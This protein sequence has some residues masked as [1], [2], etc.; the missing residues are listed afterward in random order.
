MLKHAEAE[1][2]CEALYSN[3]QN[4]IKNY[5]QHEELSLKLLKS[6][7]RTTSC[8]IYEKKW[9]EVVTFLDETL[10][11]SAVSGT[12]RIPNDEA[13]E[14]IL[15]IMMNLVKYSQRKPN[16][17]QLCFNFT[18]KVSG[19][20]T[21]KILKQC[22]DILCKMFTMC[23]K[24]KISAE[25]IKSLYSTHYQKVESKSILEEKTA[26]FLGKLL[27]NNIQL[28]EA[29]PDFFYSYHRLAIG[30]FN[31]FKY[32]KNKEGVVSCCNDIKRHSTNNMN[33]TVMSLAAKTAKAGNHNENFGK[34][35]LY[36]ATY[37]A[38]LVEDLKCQSKQKEMISTYERLY[39]VIYEV[40]VL[41]GSAN[42]NLSHL[43]QCADV[44]LKL[45]DKLPEE[46]I[47]TSIEPDRLVQ[48]IY[49]NPIT[50]EDAEICANGVALLLLKRKEL[51]S[52]LDSSRDQKKNLMKM[53]FELRQCIKLLEYDSATEYLR[54]KH[55]S[56]T[57]TNL[58]T[59]TLIEM[60]AV[61]R[62]EPE[63]STK[64]N[65]DLFPKL[66]NL[67]KCPLTLAQACQSIS[68]E[69]IKKIPI[70]LFK[71]VNK[72]LEF[73]EN[74]QFNLEVS[75]SLALNNYWIF[76]VTAETVQTDMKDKSVGNLNLKEE[77]EILKRLNES[78]R[79]FTEVV[80]HISKHKKDVEK[81]MS[82]QRL[83]GII[84][85]MAIQ[86]Y[87]RGIK[88]KDLEAFTLLWHI[89]LIDGQQL[90]P[91]LNVATFFL[92]HVELLTDSS[93]NYIKMSK[94]IKPLTI[95][96]IVA[97]SNALVDERYMMNFEEQLAT[98]QYS[99]WSYLLSL[100]VYYLQQGRH[101]DGQKRWNQFKTT[102]KSPKT[103]DKF[104]HRQIIEAKMYFCLVEINMKC[105]QRTAVNFLSQGVSILVRAKKVSRDF[106]F[107]YY[108]IYNHISMKV[109]NYSLNRLVD[110]THY[111]SLLASMI[112]SSTKRGHCVK[113]I[114]LLSLS[115]MRNLSMEKIENAKVRLNHLRMI[116]YLMSNISSQAQL[117]ELTMIIGLKEEI[118]VESPLKIDLASAV[119]YRELFKEQVRKVELP[120]DSPL[121]SVSCD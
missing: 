79:H 102:W 98:T 37:S 9:D 120:P 1:D 100:W 70:D 17:Y 50:K 3:Y 39:Q 59:F 121:K 97:E 14:E 55:S 25:G 109:L 93:G 58:S 56:T 118:L 119:V 10:V 13:Y 8:L 40:A 117:S 23:H 114:D 112:S 38:S 67:T 76:F 113:L 75:L 24:G 46:I 96:E 54:T 53:M 105:C 52:Y 110:M 20:L 74:K 94:K 99:V 57:S 106:V 51:S 86:F 30:L 31:V 49:K 90:L 68:D 62:Y 95:H 84:N 60:T 45:W 103:S 6:M 4:H 33:G 63:V 18:N 104:C 107:V 80:A 92:D 116:L 101:V 66:C 29:T 72:L 78:L 12:L 85:N 43:G 2:S 15:N 27:E 19:L 82:T 64:V 65:S 34:T 36:H 111:N 87:I 61:S 11:R 26:L 16:V 88:Y 77:L 35:L 44:L 73:E 83:I 42:L 22:N 89:T 91:I 21:G 41:K 5:S 47:S 81:I 71:K 32:I 115:I 28:F 69:V 48:S 108:Q 7:G